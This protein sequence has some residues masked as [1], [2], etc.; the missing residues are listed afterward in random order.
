MKIDINKKN[1]FLRELEVILKWDD[2][3][4]DYF[5]EVK[6]IH[7]DYQIPGYR[8]GKVPENIFRKNVGSKPLE[9]QFID[10]YINQYYQKS[11]E[12]SKLIPVNQGQI[13]KIDFEEGKNLIFTISFEVVPEFKL[14]NYQKKVTINTEKYI[15]NDKD[16]DQ[17]IEDLR[18]HHAKAQTV[19]RG[20]KSGDFIYADFC[21][22]NSEGQPIE[23]GKL[24]NHHVKIGEGLFADK[25]EEPFLDKKINDQVK[26]SVPQQS[27]NIDY[28]VKINKIEEQVLPEVNDD[29]AKLADKEISSLKELK[30]KLMD[31][32]QTNLNNENKKQFHEKIVDY[33][34][35]KTKFSP[36]DSMVDNYKKILIDDFNSKNSNSYNEETMDKNFSDAAVKNVKWYLIKSEIIKSENIKVSDQD[37]KKKIKEFEQQNSQYLDEIKKFYSD[38]SNKQKLRED[39]VNQNLFNTLEKYLINKVKDVSTDKIRDKR[40]KKG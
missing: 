10:N 39:I 28:I 21:K 35:E 22:M 40:D 3:K 32:I 31:S 29:L 15:A 1:D 25:L 36:P 9:A 30:I 27:G 17:S 13:N 6:K 5:N 24:P 16:V 23:E 2:I 18:A 20:I 8:K 34:V 26:I 37:L 33:F 38:D 11:L 7:S 4:S 14:P 19:D 12:K